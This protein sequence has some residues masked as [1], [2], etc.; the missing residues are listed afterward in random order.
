MP[1]HHRSAPPMGVLVALSALSILPL[2]MFV[3]SLPNIARDLNASFATV[4]IAVAGYA[5]A[6]ALAHLVAGILSDRFGRRPILLAGLFIFTVASVGCTLAT[7]IRVF[8]LCRLLQGSVIACYAVSL[9][10]ILDISRE[11]VGSRIGYVSAVWAM[12]PMIGPTI[13]GVLDDGF[14]WRSNFVAF[15]LLGATGLY[16]AVRYFPE[17]HHH[18]TN[19]IAQLF[20]GYGSLLR[21]SRFCAYA[22]C[23]AFSMGTLYVFLGGAPLVASQSGG[24]P[25]TLLGIYM[26]IVPVGFMAGSY[27]VGRCGTRWAPIRFILAGR[28]LTCLGLLL[29]AILSWARVGHLLAFF[30]PCICIGLGNG[31]T[32][33]VANA[34]VLSMH[35]GMAG[36]AS[37]LASAI[38]VAGAGGIAFVAGLAID[39]ADAR[40][41]VSAAMLAVASLSLAVAAFAAHREK[42]ARLG[43]DG[44]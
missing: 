3:P 14:G 42:L 22:F 23:M 18:R 13:G 20:S 8:L 31:L 29:G 27:I 34:R 11:R 24:T 33:P 7:D 39:G 41:E 10:A 35:P 26:G 25:S 4:N 43:R 1:S 19:T 16:L 40:I 21:S 2:N 28:S 44:A 36:T 15:A 17:T 6:T 30:G 38:T 32:M 5:I 9:A 37:G 12:A